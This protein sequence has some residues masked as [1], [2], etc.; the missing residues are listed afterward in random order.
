MNNKLPELLLIIG[1]FVGIWD[2]ANVG[3]VGKFVGFIVGESV[4]TDGAFVGSIVGDSVWH[5]FKPEHVWFNDNIS[6]Q[7]SPEKHVSFPKHLIFTFPSF[8]Q[9]FKSLHDSSVA[10]SILIFCVC[11]AEIFT[12]WQDPYSL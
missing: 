5:E 3:I 7:N 12:C 11:N 1:L 6:W 10:Q 8:E 9:I 4:W 2:G